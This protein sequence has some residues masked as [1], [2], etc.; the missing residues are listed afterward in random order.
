MTSQS[1]S[2]D[3]SSATPNTIQS[4]EFYAYIEDDIRFSARI[5]TNIG[6]HFS[7]VLV[8]GKLYYSFQP[9]IATRFLLFDNWA[10]KASYAQMSQYIHLLTNSG[11]SLPTDLWVPVTE[12][13]APQQSYQGTVG[14]AKTLFNDTYECSVEGYY[15]YMK[16][17]IDYAEGASF[18]G[19]NTD[20]ESNIEV[21]QGR[22][23]GKE[24]IIQRKKG[25]TTGWIGYTLSWSNRQFDNINKGEMYPYK[26]DRRHD[27]EF[28]LTH[29]FNEKIDV[30]CTWVFST[31]NAITLPIAYYQD[32][33]WY[34]DQIGMNAYS[35]YFYYGKKNSYRLKAYHRLDLGINFH[36]KKK[37]GERTINI[38]VYNAYSRQNPYFIYLF[39]DYKANTLSYHQVSLFPIIPSV[40]YNFKF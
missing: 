18:M 3:D 28:V 37:H 35:D 19:S 7:G 23:Y 30:G 40:S 36:K 17:I 16:N 12:N 34:D 27:F 31:G 14:I 32:V 5:R 4:N 10:L 13:V 24:L 33:I 9:R 39:P 15:K 22:S 11:A 21:G 6:L 25:N 1:N 2:A 38:S 26:Y 8:N 20:W 29:K